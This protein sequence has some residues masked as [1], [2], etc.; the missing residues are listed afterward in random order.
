MKYV[1][2]H[3][4]SK[5]ILFNKRGDTPFLSKKELHTFIEITRIPINEIDVYG[6][7]DTITKY[8]IYSALQFVEGVQ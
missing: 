7:E 2:I 4:N 6:V 5:E 1:C 8:S 3:K